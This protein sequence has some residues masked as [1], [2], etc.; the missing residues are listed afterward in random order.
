MKIKLSIVIAALLLVSCRTNPSSEVSNPSSEHPSS[1]ISETPSSETP[2]SE[3]P[4]SASSTP[5]TSNSLDDRTG[6]R[7]LHFLGINDFHGAIL[8]N[9]NYPGIFRL[10]SYFKSLETAK[11]NQVIKVNAG[12]FWQGSGDSNNNRGEFL[13]KAQNL[14]GFDAFTLGNHEF[15]WTDNVIT[16]NKDVSTVPFL[17]VNIMLKATNKIATNLV[18]Y[19]DTFKAST[20]V[21]KNDVNIGIIGTMGSSLESSIMA[22]NIEPYYFDPVT[23]YIID[24]ATNLRALGADMIILSTH[25]TLTNGLGEY[26]S[27]V[28]NKVVDMIFSG[29][30]HTVDDKVVNGVPI[31]QTNGRGQQ[32][33]EVSGDYNFD[34]KKF[35][36]KS[37]GLT[38]SSTIKEYSEDE[39]ML[40]LFAP[41][42]AEFAEQ[43]NEVV[44]TFTGNMSRGNLTNF[45]NKVLYDYAAPDYP[46]HKIV[47]AHNF[48]GVPVALDGGQVTYG[49]LY[50]AFP[51]DNEVRIIEEISGSALLG[52]ISNNY[53]LPDKAE[54]NSNETYTLVTI[55]YLSTYSTYTKYLPQVETGDYVRD[56]MADYMKTHGPINPA[57]Y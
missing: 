49:D 1:I 12:D 27:I 39:D 7:S 40:D 5:S 36:L 29:H 34:T 17:G 33:M 4:S 8:E 30:F 52:F 57:D 42:D 25:D 41:Y 55:D 16:H 43:K 38:Y 45:A 2:S 44:G 48:S 24:E 35:E 26:T 46:Q 32:V 51:F 3:N 15:D 47:S 19:D 31:L 22:A 9:G 13:T 50:R 6:K 53:S 37:S 56:L 11:P 18:D 20:M 14:M 23:S 10:S 54:I 28:N 21:T